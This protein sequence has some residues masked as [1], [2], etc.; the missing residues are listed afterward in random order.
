MTQNLGIDFITN[1]IRGF[2]EPLKLPELNITT[3]IPV[4]EDETLAI[5]ESSP[6]I[7][8]FI[9]KHILKSQFNLQ[10]ILRTEKDYLNI[11]MDLDIIP[12]KK[13]C[14]KNHELTMTV[15]NNIFN[16]V[17]NKCKDEHRNNYKQPIKKGTILEGLKI[18]F[19]K[20]FIFIKNFVVG[21][22]SQK[23][24]DQIGLDK[25]IGC[26]LKQRFYGIM[27]ILSEKNKKAIGG[28]GIIL[29]A[30]ESFTVKR[31]YD[32]G[33]LRLEIIIMGLVET[34]TIER[35]KRFEIIP[36]RSEESILS[37][38]VRNAKKGSIIMTDEHK[39]YMKIENIENY[40]YTKASVNHS[41]GIFVDSVTGVTTNTIE[42]NWNV[43]KMDSK[44]EWGWKTGMIN[45]KIAYRE[46]VSNLDPEFP[47]IDLLQII[48]TIL[49]SSKKVDDPNQK[50]ISNFFMLEAERRFDSKNLYFYDVQYI[51]EGRSKILKDINFN[52]NKR[53]ELRFNAVKI[54]RETKIINSEIIDIQTS[55]DQI[56]AIMLFNKEEQITTNI[57]RLKELNMDIR[58]FDINLKNIRKGLFE[59]AGIKFTAKKPIPDRSNL[60]PDFKSLKSSVITDIHSISFKLKES[61]YL[62]L[63]LTIRMLV[64]KLTVYN[65]QNKKIIRGSKINPSSVSLR[66]NQNLTGFFLTLK[67]EG[68]IYG[69]IIKGA[70]TNLQDHNKQT[71]GCN[72]IFTKEKFLLNIQGCNV[73]TSVYSGYNE[74]KEIDCVYRN[75]IVIIFYYANREYY[76]VVSKLNP[77]T[78]T[79]IANI[80]YDRSKMNANLL[81][82][83]VLM[84][85]E[86]INAN[87]RLGTLPLTIGNK[88][89]RTNEKIPFCSQSES[90]TRNVYKEQTNTNSPFFKKDFETLGSSILSEDLLFSP[91]KPNPNI[92][93]DLKSIS[94]DIYKFSKVDTKSD[95]NKSFPM[96][97][98]STIIFPIDK[99]VTSKFEMDLY[100]KN[101]IASYFIAQS[102]DNT[103]MHSNIL[104]RNFGLNISQQSLERLLS[105]SAWLDNSVINF[106]MMILAYNHLKIGNPYFITTTFFFF[107]LLNN[108][109]LSSSAEFFDHKHIFR[110]L[111]KFPQVHNSIKKIEYK[112]IFCF[113]RLYIPINSSQH[114]T[115]AVLD[116][117]TSVLYY[118]D[119]FQKI[120]ESN[121]ALLIS[122]FS[123]YARS[124]NCEVPVFKIIIINSNIQPNNNDCGVYS[125]LNAYLMDFQP[126]PYYCGNDPSDMRSYI[127][128]TILHY[129]QNHI[130]EKTKLSL[131]NDDNNL[132]LTNLGLY[133]FKVSD[134]SKTEFIYNNNKVVKTLEISLDS[135]SDVGIEQVLK[136][137]KDNESIELEKKINWCKLSI[138]KIKKNWTTIDGNKNQLILV[139]LRRNLRRYEKDLEERKNS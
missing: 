43:L 138:K 117:Q 106:S 11:F 42:S 13:F 110:Y 38:I 48:N 45:K 50:N 103:I 69:N 80:L 99:F 65:N 100:I 31:K 87:S 92:P 109:T 121:I 98:R 97:S 127:L 119:S 107:S 77:N 26:K 52:Y 71:C 111:S 1:P 96:E 37:F 57:Q 61:L 89:T 129:D 116:F 123:D 3:S 16:W 60:S 22:K 39:S 64:N 46:I 130:N 74:N 34:N 24:L 135:S 12:K 76:S 132:I 35:R 51:E 72:L 118:F 27:L 21:N 20:I 124:I 14:L 47:E 44:S 126:A 9:L 62:Y 40:N 115:L 54:R 139:N 55:N 63:S 84:L 136:K 105:A 133:S 4:I 18:S 104:V 137:K 90:K 15:N 58:K 95:I 23:F 101:Y 33:R 82:N 108:Y 75:H 67:I 114:W 131:E 53:A 93:K 17:C 112:N 6:S 78:H 8:P 125:I 66:K 49:P 81:N 5:I 59:I 7:T 28:E 36:D 83:K 70:P 113:K 41:K 29:E 86:N 122:F 94:S 68:N 85:S 88:G 10:K 128:N 32:K 73:E 2:Q 25:N 102:P 56:D 19:E 79:N 91:I 120:S 134:F 30:D